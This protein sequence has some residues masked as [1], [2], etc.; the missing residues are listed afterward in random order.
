MV[1]LKLKNIKK[2]KNILSVALKTSK[3]EDKEQQKDFDKKRIEVGKE[4]TKLSELRKLKLEEEREQRIF[5]KKELKKAKQRIRSEKQEKNVEQKIVI[6]ENVVDA[7]S[8]FN[9]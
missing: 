3:A 5:K 2:E 7:S 4:I 8:Y 6:I 1:S 9:C